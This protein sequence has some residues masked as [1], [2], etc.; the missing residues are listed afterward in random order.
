MQEKKNV[1]HHER[2]RAK[3]IMQMEQDWKSPW[4]AYHI[5]PSNTRSTPNGAPPATIDERIAFPFVRDGSL[6][7]RV[8]VSG[9]GGHSESDKGLITTTQMVISSDHGSPPIDIDIVTPEP[10][11]ASESMQYSHLWAVLPVPA[12]CTSHLHGPFIVNTRS[13]LHHPRPFHKPA[14]MALQREVVGIFV[15]TK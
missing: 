13:Y 12:G 2:V 15:T 6:V 1:V 11:S 7:Q 4:F 10:A 9:G 5:T 14:R 8:S 3:K